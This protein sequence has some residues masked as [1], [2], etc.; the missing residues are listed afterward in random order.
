V[1]R[2]IIKTGNS[3]A[4]TIPSAMAEEWGINTSDDV[5]VKVIW[6]KKKLVYTFS[7]K[8]KQMPLFKKKTSKKQMR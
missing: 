6:E 2:K 1:K 7:S 3:L 5:Q 8:S 4:V